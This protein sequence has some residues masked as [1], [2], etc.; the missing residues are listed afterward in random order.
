MTKSRDGWKIGGVVRLD[1]VLLISR[2]PRKLAE[3]GVAK[4]NQT[5]LNI[6]WF[7]VC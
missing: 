6:A 1:T 4:G 5:P 3:E 7:G 2:K